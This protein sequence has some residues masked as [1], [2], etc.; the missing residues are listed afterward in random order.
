MST[1][2]TGNLRNPSSREEVFFAVLLIVLG[3]LILY[4]GPWLALLIS[5][6]IPVWL[7]ADARRRARRAAIDAGRRIEQQASQGSKIGA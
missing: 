2:E 3:M 4:G 1:Q 5:A 7:V 6:A